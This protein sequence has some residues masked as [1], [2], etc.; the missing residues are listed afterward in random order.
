MSHRKCFRDTVH[1]ATPPPLPPITTLKVTRTAKVLE[2]YPWG[3]FAA[4]YARD[5]LINNLNNKVIELKK[6]IA[7]GKSERSVIGKPPPSP[8]L[9]QKKGSGTEG[10]ESVSRKSSFRKTTSQADE[11]VKKSAGGGGVITDPVLLEKL[12]ALNRPI[13]REVRPTRPSLSA[14]IPPPK[15]E[16]YLD[17]GC[18]INYGR[19]LTDEVLAADRLLVEAAKKTM[20]V[21]GTT[22]LIALLEGSRLIVA[23]VGDS[24]GVMCDSKG[25]AIPLSFDHKPQQRHRKVPAALGRSDAI[26]HPTVSVASVTF[27]AQHF[28]LF[29]LFTVFIHL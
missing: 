29:K 8:K 24:R 11:C 6:L 7:D 28:S 23:N 18:A 15:V 12:E 17:A 13:T 2:L 4:N 9:D 22:A 3:S 16:S 1:N 5:N 20:D 10:G 25:N 27:H 21:A 14:A 26:G 19:L